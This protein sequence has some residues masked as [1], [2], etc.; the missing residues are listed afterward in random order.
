MCTTSN[1]CRSNYCR[2]C[3]HPLSISTNFFTNTA[4]NTTV[5]EVLPNSRYCNTLQLII[6]TVIQLRKSQ[7]KKMK[8]L[9]NTP[10]LK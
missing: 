6:W 3:P 2:V 1:V 8:I 5:T 7:K 10:E 9:D 4:V